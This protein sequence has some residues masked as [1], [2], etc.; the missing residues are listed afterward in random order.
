MRLA[1]TSGDEGI[2]QMKKLHTGH[3]E[4]AELPERSAEFL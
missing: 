1:E 3:R 2:G 4:Q